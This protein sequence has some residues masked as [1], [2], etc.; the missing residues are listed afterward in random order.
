MTQCW[1]EPSRCW[2]SLWLEPKQ[3][4]PGIRLIILSK[5]QVIDDLTEGPHARKSYLPAHISTVAKHCKSWHQDLLL[6]EIVA[7]TPRPRCQIPRRAGDTNCAAPPS[8]FFFF[9]FS[10]WAVKL[11]PKTAEGGTLHVMPLSLSQWEVWA[12]WK[13]C[14]TREDRSRWLTDL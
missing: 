1:F 10:W 4:H 11:S 5:L 2:S 7:M 8:L 9:F 14:L 6:L 3:H 12:K 13:L